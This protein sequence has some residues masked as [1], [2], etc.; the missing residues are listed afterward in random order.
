VPGT[1]EFTGPMPPRGEQFCLVCAATVKQAA[2][3][4]LK[5]A[6]QAALL[7]NGK[8]TTFDLRQCQAF[9]AGIPLAVATGLFGPMMAPPL[10]SGLMP[11]PVPLCWTHLLGLTLQESAVMPAT[12]AMMPTGPGGAVML[13]RR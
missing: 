4:E 11:F 7:D 13:D 12:P 1:V 3:A 8:S 9:K 6:I 5:D 2:M 10:G